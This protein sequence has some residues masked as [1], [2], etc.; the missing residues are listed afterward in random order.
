MKKNYIGIREARINLSRLIRDVRGGM[1][2][3]IT[4]RGTPVARLVPAEGAELTLEERLKNFESCGLIESCP[5]CDD[6]IS[7]PI[8]LP[9]DLLRRCFKEEKSD[10]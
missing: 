9:R 7:T 8:E 3:I 4:D 10:E 1:E 6:D 5:G 2:I